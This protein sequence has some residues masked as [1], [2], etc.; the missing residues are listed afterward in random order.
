[1][2]IDLTSDPQPAFGSE[3]SVGTDCTQ[4]RGPAHTG[5][6]IFATGA[7]YVFNGVAEGGAAPAATARK[8]FGSD[9]AGSGIQLVFGGAIAGASYATVCIAAQT[10]TVD[11]EA[12]T[13]PPERVAP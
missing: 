13:L 9:Q 7:V 8:S 12:Y 1:M 3:S 5:L 6:A 10:G 4:I 11:V 2:A